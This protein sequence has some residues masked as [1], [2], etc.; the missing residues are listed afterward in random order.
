[1]DKKNNCQLIL[2]IAALVLYLALTLA[3]PFPKTAAFWVA[4]VFGLLAIAAQAYILKTAF[5]K[6]EPVKSKFYGYPIARIGII[7]LAVQ[8]IVSLVLMAIGFAC[9]VPVWI[10]VVICVVVTAVFVIGFI[11]ADIMRG[12]VEH[13]DM[14][15][16]TD[17]KTMR[18]LQSKTADIIGLCADEETK[19]AVAALADKFRYSDPV[20]G[21]ATRELET[22][23][24]AAADELQ[25]A[26]LD[27]DFS[28]AKQLCVKIEASLN[29]RNRLCKLNK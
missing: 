2:G 14:K 17:V 16:K 26:V 11:S 24:T 20:T 25:A 4:F 10:A 28:A 7:Y 5:D 21:D 23:L 15:L 22:G 1:M 9:K 12:E 3:V 27:G 13:Q 29:E 18:A 6:G 19:K 8:L